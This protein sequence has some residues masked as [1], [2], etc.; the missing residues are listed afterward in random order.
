MKINKLSDN[1][2]VRP[3][4]RSLLQKAVRRGYVELVQKV[5]FALAERGDST[6]LHTRA[7]VIVFEECWPC[8]SLLTDGTPSAVTLES[9]TAMRKNKNAAGLGSLAYAASEGDLYAIQN[10][11]D[12]I[13]VKIVAAA[14]KRPDS[15]FK[16]AISQCNDEEQLAVVLAS[17]RFISKASWPWDKAFMVAGAYLSCSGKVPQTQLSKILPSAPF[18]FWVAVDKHTPQGKKAFRRVALDLGVSERALGWASF[19]FESAMTNDLSSSPWW[20]SESEWRFGSLGLSLD[21]ATKLWVSAAPFIEL[22]V[23]PQSDNLLGLVGDDGRGSM[24]D[25]DFTLI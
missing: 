6:W 10:S 8:A 2:P 23:K 7:G 22:M 9:V 12:P 5:V 19:Y 14:L 13:A 1:N 16:W 15:F 24:R 11:I 21:E 20:V 4:L 17:Q 25:G 18:P 3:L